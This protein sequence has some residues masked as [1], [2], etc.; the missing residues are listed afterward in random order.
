VRGNAQVSEQL[1]RRIRPFLLRRTKL[2]VDAQLPEKIVLQEWCDL[3][4]E[5]RQLYG[6]LQ[7]E[8]KRVR[9]ALR[10][11]EKVSYTANV[12]PVL[13][14]LKQ[15]CDHPALATHEVE[16][17]AGIHQALLPA[18]GPR[19]LGAGSDRR[20][21]PL[22]LAGR[23]EKFD[24]IMEKIDE[25]TQAGEK[26]IVFSHFLGMLTLLEAAVRQRNIPYIRI[27]GSSEDREHL[28]REFQ[29]GSAQ[30]ALLSILA[31]GYGLNLQAANH[32]IHADRW[33]NPAVEDQATDRVHRLGQK[34]RVYVYH[35][36]VQ[37]TLEERIDDLLQKKRGIADEIVAAAG[38][39]PRKWSREELLELLRPLDADAP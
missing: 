33:W 34:R 36:L 37:G 8:V 20:G 15:I 21:K 31:A 9:E 4:K 30:V 12:L 23:S 14:K 35:I 25:I 32:V 24:W 22:P 7:D 3:T 5:Q 19:N 6:G 13:T 11:G 10:Q 2:Q 1:G 26:V 29:Q 39:G 16:G 18:T 27:D 38:D 17:R 28:V